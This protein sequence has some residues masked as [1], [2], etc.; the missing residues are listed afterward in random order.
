MQI[1]FEFKTLNFLKFNLLNISLNLNIQNFKLLNIFDLTILYS[2]KHKNEMN[3]I[4][5][6]FEMKKMPHLLY[7]SYT[8]VIF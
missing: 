7:F 3:Q 6:Y 1:F 8:I 4:Y 2:F 5:Y